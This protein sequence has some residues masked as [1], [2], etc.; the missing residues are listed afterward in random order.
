MGTN[1]LFSLESIR[2]ME[3]RLY[4]GNMPQEMTEQDLR[5]MFSEAGTVRLVEVVVDHKTDRPRG[6]AFVT[7]DSQDEAE[8]AVQMFNAKEVS[9]RT[10]RVNIFLPR[11][12]RPAASAGSNKP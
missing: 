1:I 12:E 3:I 9:G 8:K 2:K 7:M 11:E 10:L 6:F 5:T 4:V